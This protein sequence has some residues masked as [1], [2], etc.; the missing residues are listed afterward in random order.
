MT[1]FLLEEF[2]DGSDSAEMIVYGFAS[3]FD[4]MVEHME[5]IKD[6]TNI[7]CSVDNRY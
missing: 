4:V 1:G 3:I 2:P 6:N 5:F 7:P